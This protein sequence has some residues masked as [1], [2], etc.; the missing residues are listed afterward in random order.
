M[1]EYLDSWRTFSVRDIER[2]GFILSVVGFRRAYLAEGW[3]AS[4]IRSLLDNYIVVFIWYAQIVTWEKPALIV[5]CKARCEAAGVNRDFIHARCKAGEVGGE[6]LENYR[7]KIVEHFF[8]VHGF[9]KLK[10]GEARKAIRFATNRT[11]FSYDWTG[12][13][14]ANCRVAHWDVSRSPLILL[15]LL[16]F[17]FLFLH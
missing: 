17:A 1:T 10:P 14:T 3:A 16:V 15:N 8:P 9:G 5:L 2:D 11:I 6:A 4:F 12:Y 7:G 13:P